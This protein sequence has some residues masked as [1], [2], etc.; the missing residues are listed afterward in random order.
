M[1]VYLR[2]L[3]ILLSIGIVIFSLLPSDQEPADL[4]DRETVAASP[5]EAPEKSTQS[6]VIRD[7]LGGAALDSGS[8][9][10]KILSEVNELRVKQH[11]EL[12][13]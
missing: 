9:A 4:S 3:V 10:K 2:I 1:K 12:N 11:E 8:K 13:R 6:G 7:L 5:G